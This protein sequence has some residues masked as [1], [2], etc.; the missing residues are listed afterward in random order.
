[1][2]GLHTQEP[3]LSIKDFYT[4]YSLPI[5]IRSGTIYFGSPL[6]VRIEVA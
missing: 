6:N 2:N 5:Q 4:K 3:E 1:M